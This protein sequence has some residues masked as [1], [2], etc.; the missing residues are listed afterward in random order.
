VDDA[1][2]GND[3]VTDTTAAAAAAA[4]YEREFSRCLG[5]GSSLRYDEQGTDNKKPGKEVPIYI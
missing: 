3:L 4:I 1:Q 5:L 2:P